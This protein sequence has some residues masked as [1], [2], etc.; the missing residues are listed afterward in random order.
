MYNYGGRVMA[1]VKIHNKARGVTYVYESHSYWDKELKQPRS[2]RKLIGKV[3]PETGE[4]IPTGKKGH[5]K[6]STNQENA[7]VSHSVTPS[8]VLFDQSA[9]ISEKDVL[10]QDL[11]KQ[12]ADANKEIS[13]YRR[14][15]SKATRLLSESDGG[16]R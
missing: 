3:D 2:N 1:I 15:I 5:R 9:L 14:L 6:K 4:T 8:S 7:S 13:R 10:I 16:T 11:K 12:L